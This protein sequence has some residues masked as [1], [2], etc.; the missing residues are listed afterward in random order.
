MRDFLDDERIIGGMAQN[1]RRLWGRVA[2][3]SFVLLVAVPLAFSKVL[4]GTFQGPVGPV[5]PGFEAWPLSS[6]GLR[7]RAWFHPSTGTRPAVLIIHGLGDNL[8]SYTEHAARFSAL[9]YPVLLLDV[10]GHGGSQGRFCTMAAREREDVRAGMD[11]LRAHGLTGQGLVMMGHSMGAVAVLRAAAGVPD[12]RAV[13]VEAP[14]DTFR[15]TVAHHAKLLYGLPRWAPFAPLAILDA[16]LIAGFDADDVDAVAAARDIHAPL[17]AIADGAD[18]RMPPEVVQRVFAAHQGPGEMWVCPG[19]DHL[20]AITNP[21][22]W[23]R[24]LGFVERSLAG[25]GTVREPENVS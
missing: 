19:V 23:K 16:E 3:Y 11:A 24:V 9:G 15:N 12:V 8:E 6:Q 2:F 13:V 17:M 18:P 22:Y 10:R 25:S 21:E 20:G 1:H 14:F 7:L 4:L 5:P